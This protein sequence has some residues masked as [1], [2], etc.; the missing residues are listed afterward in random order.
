MHVETLTGISGYT[1]PLIIQEEA[2]LPDPDLLVSTFLGVLSMLRRYAPLQ[3]AHF[4]VSFPDPGAP[5]LWPE[6]WDQ[7]QANPEPVKN[8]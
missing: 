4:P 7:M 5:K 6:C 3:T 1:A 8:D 2:S